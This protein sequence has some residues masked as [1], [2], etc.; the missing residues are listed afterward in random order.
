MGL[1]KD[2]ATLTETLMKMKEDTDLSWETAIS[3][4]VNAK[5]SLLSVHGFSPYQIVYGR[6]PNLPSNIVNKPPAL[7]GETICR[8]MGKHLTGIHADSKAF[9]AFESSEKIGRALRKQIRPSGEKFNNGDK[10]YFL[11]DN[12]WKGPGWVIGQDN[13]VV[14]IRYGGTMV[15][16]HESRIKRDLEK[17]VNSRMTVVNSSKSLGR[18]DPDNDESD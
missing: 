16:V 2:N 9:I 1:W 18:A 6:N 11:R 15:R 14:F 17:S 10:V 3:W 8:F 13:V 7:E 4:A 12:K 5:N